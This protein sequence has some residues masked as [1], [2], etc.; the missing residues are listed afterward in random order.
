MFH[1]LE[2]Y[3]NSKYEKNIFE[4][5]ALKWS[6]A[7]A[8]MGNF[9]VAIYCKLMEGLKLK[10]L[11]EKDQKKHILDDMLFMTECIAFGFIEK[12][13]QTTL[14]RLVPKYKL[15]LDS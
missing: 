6:N 13:S 9:P 5:E 3:Y 11:N 14:S 2:A 1:D 12:L 7:T 15:R 10:I 8:G 4:D